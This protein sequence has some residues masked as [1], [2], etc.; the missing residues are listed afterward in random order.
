MNWYVV[1]TNVNKE[2]LAEKHL[3]RQGFIT[4]F[5]KYKK[6]ISHARKV[7]TVIQPLFPR[8]IFVKIDLHSQ[9]WASINYTYGINRLVSMN[10]IPVK[11]SKEVI[12]DIKLQEDNDGLMNISYAQTFKEGDE[13]KI[14][15]GIFSGVTG[16]F[17]GLTD[18]DR[19]KVLL[20]LLGKEITYSSA[21]VSAVR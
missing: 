7:T 1:N 3:N 17:L 18:N 8:Y 13:V 10:N 2:Q 9:R 6:I 21:S 20:N 11:V 15:D 4:Y 19:V 14:Y 5:P 12:S 16:L